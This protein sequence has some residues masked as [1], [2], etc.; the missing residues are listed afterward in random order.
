MPDLIAGEKYHATVSILR[1]DHSGN[2]E[3]VDQGYG[4]T[5]P[6]AW[7][8]FQ[9]NNTTLNVHAVLKWRR[10]ESRRWISAR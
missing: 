9:F 6:D 7:V 2:Q 1:Q 8:S 4:G 3:L 10:S 5:D